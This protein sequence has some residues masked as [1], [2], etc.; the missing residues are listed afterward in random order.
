[1]RLTHYCDI[2]NLFQDLKLYSRLKSV[3]H[4]ELI[5]LVIMIYIRMSLYSVLLHRNVITK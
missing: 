1:M 2:L 5:N 3:D 4:V